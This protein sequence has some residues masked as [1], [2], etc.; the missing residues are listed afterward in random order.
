MKRF[1]IFVAVIAMCLVARTANIQAQNP[2]IVVVTAMLDGG[3]EEPTAVL[4]GAFGKATIT[5]NRATRQIGYVID[6]WDFPFRATA[7]H[8]HVGP[9]RSGSGP[10]MIN[11][12]VPANSISAFRISGT[13]TPADLVP[14]PANG[15]NSFED[16]M[17]AIA[18]GV[19]YAN[20]H[21]EGNPGG[22][23]RGRL[24]PA[25]AA[26]NTFSGVNTCPQ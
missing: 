14:R 7:A 2:D 5:V 12:V 3:Q 8:I 25:S 4:T 11:F 10:V 22:E 26:A 20:V 6:V 17:M 16:A 21:S 24:C 19:T 15:I 13:A 23:I 9:P 18:A 1:G